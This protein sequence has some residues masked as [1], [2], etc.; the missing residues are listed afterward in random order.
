MEQSIEQYISIFK[1]YYEKQEKDLNV[2]RSM[3]H[4]L[5]AHLIVLQYYLD[6]E[7]YENAKNYLQKIKAVD[8][9]NLETRIDTGNHLL[10]AIVSECM[11]KCESPITLLCDRDFPAN[12][13]ISDFDLCTIFSNGISNAVEACTRLEH[14]EKMIRLDFQCEGRE[15]CMTIENPIEWEVDADCF[16]GRTTKADKASHGFGI[17][18][19]KKAVANYNGMVQFFVEE[20]KFR[21]EI[22]FPDA[23]NPI[24]L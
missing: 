1:G 11:K 14:S 15:F 6:V 20:D 7:N 19:I 17:G 16:N 5:Q 3:K 8:A 23:V 4:D 9:L 21:M 12:V 13:E 24:E 22:R 18:N 10:N 2:L